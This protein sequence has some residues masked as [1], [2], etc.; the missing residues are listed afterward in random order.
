MSSGDIWR[1]EHRFEQILKDYEAL[2]SRIARD[3][4]NK[5]T[6]WDDLQ[7]LAHIGLYQAYLH[8]DP[9]KAVKF[10]TYAVYWIK[11]QVLSAF[12][13]KSVTTATDE[14]RGDGHHSVPRTL[15]IT[16]ANDTTESAINPGY[17][18]PSLKL[19]LDMPPL[20]REI[21]N[22]SIGQQL[23]LKEISDKLQLSVERIKQHKQKALRRLRAIHPE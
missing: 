15:N 22:L 20:E 23:S 18:Y 13:D 10:S 19:P 5:G 21:I 6:D 17:E 7:Q 12:S 2:A 1:Q 8:Y 9:H 11:K 4:K 3:Y 16:T 14:P